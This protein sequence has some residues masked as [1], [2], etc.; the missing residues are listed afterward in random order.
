MPPSDTGL[1]ESVELRSVEAADETVPESYTVVAGDTLYR[2]AGL[3]GVAVEDI[4]ELN[5]IADPNTLQVGQLLSLPREVGLMAPRQRLI[6]DSELILSPAYQAFDLAAVVAE[7]GGFLAA[8]REEVEG[9]ER[10]GVE[11]VS[12]VSQQYSVGP[13]PLLAMLEYESGWL[14]NPAPAQRAYPLNVPEPVRADLYHQLSWV[15]NRMNEGY[16]GQYTGRA[17]QL[18][19]KDG[20]TALYDPETNPGT[21]AIQNVFAVKG[22]PASWSRALAADGFIATYARLFGDPWERAIEPLIPDE[23]AQPSLAL[24]WPGGETWYY[25]GGP[26][27]GWGDLSGWAALDFVPPDPTGCQPSAYWAAAAT[28]G[29]IVRSQNGE[30]VLDLDRDGFAGTGWTLLYMHMA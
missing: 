17:T 30:V 27:G 16:Y 11:I 15:A 2:I 29:K 10:S 5:G 25:T 6:P 19:F 13:R 8:Y 28:D 9:S 22:E 20:T 1:G 3:F 18:Q 26:H 24:P 4:M 12:M 21:A 14:T 23:L 7:Q